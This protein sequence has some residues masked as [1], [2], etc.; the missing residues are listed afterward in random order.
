MKRLVIFALWIF[1]CGYVSSQRKVMDLAS[2]GDWKIWLDKEAVWA[3]DKLYLPGDFVLSELPVNLP[4]CGW[5]ALFEG[6]GQPCAMPTTVEEQFGTTHDWTYHGVSWFYTSFR[7]PSSW[8]GKR[9]LLD[10]GKYN[11]RIEVFLNGRLVGYD[12]VGL[13]P[14][15]CDLT[16]AL[17]QTDGENRLA[18]RI[19]SAGGGRGWEDF[20]PIKWGTQTLL[21]DKDF[22][23]IGGKVMLTAVDSTFISDVFVKN[24]L[25]AKGNRIEVQATVCHAAGQDAEAVYELEIDDRNTGKNLFRKSYTCVLQPGENRLTRTLTVPEARQWS[26]HTPALYTCRVTLKA[27][28]AADIYEQ[29]F[30]FR[31]FDVKQR[32][33]RTHYYLNGERI[34]LKSAIDWSIYA[35]NGL[36]PTDEAARRS[37]EAVKAA[38][39]NSLNFHRRAGDTPLFDC[40]DR[41]GV[42]IYEEPGGFHSGGQANCNI[43]TF[44]FARRQ[45]YERLKRM[46]LRDRNHPSL[47]IYTLCNEDNRFTLARE[48]GM[49]IIHQY[50]PTRLIVNS[51]GGDNGGFSKGGIAHIRPYGYEVRMD[52]NDHHTVQSAVSLPE[53]DL[54]REVSAVLNEKGER[55]D[56]VSDDSLAVTYWGEVRCYA[57][58]FNYPLMYRQGV[59]NGKGY[60]LSMYT[61]QARKA[62]ELFDT[63]RLEGMANGDIRSVYDLTRYAG[64]GQYYTNGRLSQVILSNDFSDGYA[65]NGWSPGPDMPDEWSSALLDQNRNMN[66][67]GEHLSY[68]NRPL[69]VAI[70]RLSGKYVN[71]G[72]S[73][74][75]N[76]FLINEGRLAAGNYALT[77][78]VKDGSGAYVGRKTVW[79]VHVR[80]GDVFAQTICKDHALV[81][82]PSWMSGYL[83]LEGELT[84]DGKVVADGKEQVLLKNRASQGRRLRGIRVA[85]L[86]WPAA[87]AALAE[88]K[89][90]CVPLSGKPSVILLGRNSGEESWDAAL[91]AV[92]AGA[93]LIVQLDSLGGERLLKKGL[94]NTPIQAW[95]GL[96]TGFWNGNGSSYID[97][98][99]GDQALT[100]SH[101]ISTRSWEATGQLRGFYPFR[102]DYP[103][104]AYGLYF[105]HQYKRNA[106]FTEATNTLVTYGEIQY[107][108]GR[109]L[110]DT[111]YWVDEGTAFADLLFFNMIRHYRK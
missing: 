91:D 108:K 36:F 99:A 82:D 20:Q 13:L 72:D 2:T 41:L 100:R 1:V 65:I 105:A 52:Y 33:G 80:G 42:Y 77:L 24:L 55:M 59:Q 5:D 61:S 4:T 78:R 25:P 27:P 8:Q 97:V 92:R 69:Q 54:N 66:S 10:I 74:R 37:I 14:Y 15:R 86:D 76:I 49:R 96:Q 22:S 106:R 83:T 7:L 71:P 57:G 85:V 28:Q 56:H 103:Q 95:G 107:G 39:H 73:I 110:L 51:S 6:K 43:D 79:N 84:H 63:C 75:V 50:D 44:D 104:R 94:L 17:S 30:G 60:D 109:I 46:V 26:E 70:M 34:R 48:T 89:V 53:A 58:T 102:S 18:L 101:V 31:V 9:I 38:G 90:K 35:F 81:A 40:A 88:A 23:G 11:H 16:P 21:P 111:S 32:N 67:F 3:E 47:L 68:W 29:A 45:I 62:Q 93:N 98:F 19:T 12:A 64:Q 87:G